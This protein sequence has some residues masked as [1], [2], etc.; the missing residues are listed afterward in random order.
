MAV[1]GVAVAFEIVWHLVHHTNAVAPA[2][3]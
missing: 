1:L 2:E 3:P